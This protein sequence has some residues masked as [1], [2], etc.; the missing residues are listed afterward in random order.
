[1]N[2]KIYLFHYHHVSK[3]LRFKL[4]PS[5]IDWV[6]NYEKTRWFLVLRLSRPRNN[7]LNE[8]LHI[9]NSIV[10]QFGQPP[11][12]ATATVTPTSST[13]K[14]RRITQKTSAPADIEDQSEAFHISI[15]WALT[16]PSAKLLAATE[17]L[18]EAKRGEVAAMS[19]DVKEVKAKIG[20]VIVNMLLTEK[21]IEGK[22]LF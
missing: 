12:Y 3:A 16:A 9:S 22:G 14:K 13:P 10:Q 8:L 11:L 15:A 2:P 6:P 5:T 17:A 19:I 7:E 18:G 20:N 4:S 1:M 21:V